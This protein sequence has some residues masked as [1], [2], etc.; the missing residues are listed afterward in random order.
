MQN[1]KVDF[2]QV[3]NDING[4]P[5]YVCHFLNFISLAS[6]DLLDISQRYELA[7]KRARTIGGK[8]YNIK[9]NGGGIV[10][11]SYNISETEKS[12]NDLLNSLS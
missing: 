4:N 9:N 6:D 2:T 12:I 5:R 8:K 1:R 7:V 10:F 3:N 11:K